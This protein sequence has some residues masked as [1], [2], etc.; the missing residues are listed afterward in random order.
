M[1]FIRGLLVRRILTGDMK[2]AACRIQVESIQRIEISP[3]QILVVV[4]HGHG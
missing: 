1:R 4:D 3:N 2:K